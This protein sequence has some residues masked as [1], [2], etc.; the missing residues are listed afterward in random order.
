M[1]KFKNKSVVSG[2]VSMK[3]SCSNVLFGV[4]QATYRPFLRQIL[5]EVFHPDRLECPDIEHMSGGLTDLL[6]TG[7]SMFMKVRHCSHTHTHLYVMGSAHIPCLCQLPAVDNKVPSSIAWTWPDF[8]ICWVSF[9]VCTVDPK[10]PIKPSKA[11]Q[12]NSYLPT[13]FN[14]PELQFILRHRDVWFWYTQHYLQLYD[15]KS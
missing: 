11:A 8:T 9:S 15:Q 1:S 3:L 2:D 12:S 13:T 6:K 5:E 14:Y 4:L 10:S 7:F